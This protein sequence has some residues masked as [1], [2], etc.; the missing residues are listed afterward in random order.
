MHSASNVVLLRVESIPLAFL[1]EFIS[2]IPIELKPRVNLV[3][4][5][6]FHSL[7]ELTEL[8]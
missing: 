1:T 8:K 5:L 2:F 3:F 6:T 7:P 4:L